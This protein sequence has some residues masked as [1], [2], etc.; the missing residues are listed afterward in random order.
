MLVVTKK[1]FYT[2][3]VQD[4]SKLTAMKFRQRHQVACQDGV[5]HY[6][7]WQKFADCGLGLVPRACFVTELAANAN[8]NFNTRSTVVDNEGYGS[9]ATV[10]ADA[11]GCMIHSQPCQRG[12][13]SGEG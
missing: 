3:E 5:L 13:A 6:V 9:A 1:R 11:N 8:L 4:S 7:D 2:L 10:V 12:L